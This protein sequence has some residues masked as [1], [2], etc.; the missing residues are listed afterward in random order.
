[1]SIGP[2]FT[3]ALVIGFVGA[4]LAPGLPRAQQAS[5]RVYVTN[6]GSGDLTVIDG[7]SRQIIAT[8]ALGTRPR[9]IAADA[10]H[11]RLFVALSGSPVAGPGVDDSALPPPDKREDGIA[12]IDANRNQLVRVL[13]G[14]SDPEQVALS[15]NGESLYVASEDTGKGIA[16]DVA[17]GR[18]RGSVEV[19]GEPEGVAVHP[20]RNIVYFSSEVGNSVVVSDATRL[21]GLSTV[22]VGQRPRDI[23]V[24]PDGSR[25]YVSGE[26]DASLVVLDGN[27]DAVITKLTVPGGGARPKGVVVSGDSERLYVS[28]GRGGEVVA[29]DAKSM[30]VLGSVKVGAR[31]WGLA[32]S[33]DGHTLYVANGPSDDV[34]VVTTDP[35]R[36][37]ATVKVG[38]RPWGVAVLPVK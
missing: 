22:A 17:T 30:S 25:A 18:V 4:A 7:Q 37:E 9:G 10:R 1:M 8:V 14:S 20:R 34:S 13:R 32:L 11:H 19:G 24:A 21:R 23:A 15:V 5:Y 35:L 6:E 26:S 36:V 12:I 16:I 38:K 33:P 29:Y 2:R 31:P 28:T 3:L 27:T